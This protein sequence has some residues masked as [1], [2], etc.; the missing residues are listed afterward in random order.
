MFPIIPLLAIAAIIGGVTTLSW[1]SSLSRE[2][3]I[4][5]DRR[6]NQLAIQWFRR[7]FHD[8]NEDQKAQIEK[9]VKKELS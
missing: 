1:Y 2:E 7:K 5:A 4:A 8:L 6:M 9:Q 3:Q